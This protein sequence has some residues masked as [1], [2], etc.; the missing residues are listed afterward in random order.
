V[1]ETIQ[2]ITNNNLASALVAAAIIGIIGGA[3]KWQRD[4]RD[5]KKILD[6]M[7]KSKS[8]TDFSFRSTEA[9]SSHS[10]IT[11][12]RVAELCSKHKQIKRNSKEKQSW[13]IVD[14][15]EDHLK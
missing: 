14:S 3:W 7:L 12:N 15:Q 1:T 13:R 10:G 11:E 6:F 5:R 2:F 8:N 9:I 4:H